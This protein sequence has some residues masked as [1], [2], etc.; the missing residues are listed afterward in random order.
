MLPIWKF[1]V[2]SMSCADQSHCEKDSVE[3]MIHHVACQE[4]CK[5]VMM[6]RLLIVNQSI[7]VM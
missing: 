5:A 2:C 1:E 4:L 3:N 7:N 6:L